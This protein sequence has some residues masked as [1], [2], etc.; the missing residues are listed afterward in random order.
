MEE[1]VQVMRDEKVGSVVVEDDG[2][3]VGIVT[4]RDIALRVLGEGDGSSGVTAGE[5]MTGDP[6]TADAGDGVYD[7]VRKMCS[8]EVRRIPIVDE[9]ELVGIVTLD[10]LVVLLAAELQNLSGVIQ[11]ESP[12]Y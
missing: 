4:D 8:E 10:D 2:T 1:M 7:V 9:G 3:P 5:V 6:V 12:P 11:S